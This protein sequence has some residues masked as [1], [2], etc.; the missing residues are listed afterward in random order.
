MK[1]LFKLFETHMTAI[2]FAEAG[3][4]ETARLILNEKKAT[5]RKEI[6]DSNRKEKRLKL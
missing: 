3:E 4:H 6:R 5:K 2:A 1:K